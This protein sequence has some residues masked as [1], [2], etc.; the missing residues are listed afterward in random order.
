MR[1][2]IYWLKKFIYIIFFKYNNLKNVF[3]NKKIDKVCLSEIQSYHLAS[4]ESTHIQDLSI[5]ND[6]SWILYSKIFNYFN[7]KGIEID[8]IKNEKENF[9]EDQ[10]F[11][12]KQV[13]NN[14]K[15][16]IIHSYNFLT[17]KFLSNNRNFI[18]GTYLPI[19]E[20]KKLEILFGQ[21]PTFY[22]P[23]YIKYS[24]SN[25]NL[26]KQIFLNKECSIKEKIIR[27]L[28]PYYLPTF[29]LENF[30]ILK[31]TVAKH[32]YPKNPKFIF[33]SNIFES[34][35][36]FKYYL[37]NTMSFNKKPKY[38][39]GQ[40]GNGYFTRIDNNFRIEMITS[41]YFISW[42]EISNDDKKIISLFNLKLPK[43]KKKK[44]KDKIVVVFRSLGYQ[45]VPYDR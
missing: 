5:D 14:L 2:F 32:N 41:D 33:T 8:I 13:K 12:E 23:P 3:E 36:A 25:F 17:N 7:H 20:E 37:A 6:W 26:R 29:M 43:N 30:R 40:H 15:K 31:D 38:F 10:T 4:H 1:I 21:V 9:Y 11:F 28:L 16:K 27:D 42:G 19:F 34:D 24:S 44:N 18:V 22:I 39:V 35:E 45:T